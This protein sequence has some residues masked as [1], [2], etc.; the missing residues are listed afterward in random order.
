V[1]GAV[2][3]AKATAVEAVAESA[4]RARRADRRNRKY[5]R[6]RGR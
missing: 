4:L 6:G 3:T 1:E 2:E 5:D